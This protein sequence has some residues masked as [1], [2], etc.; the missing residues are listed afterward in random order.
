VTVYGSLGDLSDAQLQ[1][2]L[3]RFD[4]GRLVSAEAF[5]VGL[6]GKNVG[7]RTDRG[8][9]VLRG[10]PWPAHVDDQFRCERFW[11][12][13]VRQ[14]S[15]VPV[16]WPFH[17]EADESLFGWP[18][19]L[20]P[21]MPGTTQRDAAGVAAL[22][23]AAADLRGVTVDAFGS[24]SPVTD[25]IEPFPGSALEWLS[26]RTQVWIDRCEHR[27]LTTSD[28]EWLRSLM[29]TDLDD[30][31]PTYVHHDLKPDNTVC[32]DGEIS[33]LFDL[34]EGTT[35]DP[36]EDLART[37]WDVARHDTALVGVFLRAYE[38]AAGVRVPLDRLWAYVVL[39][40]LVIW[41]FGTRP[42]QSWFTEPSFAEWVATFA[43]PT[44]AA[45]DALIEGEG[46]DDVELRVPRL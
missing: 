2:A 45:L 26:S 37:T 8:S 46:R 14:R 7:I 5:T 34:G 11:A 39:D 21:W 3:D 23:R 35:G 24:W 40:L 18:F 44:I 28:L 33:G 13:C 9:W 15:T 16:P 41:E 19:Q 32:L 12:S 6:F 4:L 20:T 25:A 30:V 29:P 42:A 22:G 17:I 38:Q 27:P 36:I 43:A 10:D 1:A 31:A